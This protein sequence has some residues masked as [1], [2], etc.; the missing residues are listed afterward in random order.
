[1]IWLGVALAAPIDS[2]S[3]EQDDG[4]LTPQAG[5]LQWEWGAP[6]VGPMSGATGTQAWGTRLDGPYLNDATGRLQ[7]PQR[8][9]SGIVEP[10]LVFAHWSDISEGDAAWIE[11]FVDGSWVVLDPPYGYPSSDGFSGSTL[12]WET[13]FF[14]LGDVDDLS[15]VRLVFEA[16]A[17]VQGAGWFIDDL[18]LWDGDVVPPRIAIVAVPVDTEDL[19]G[20]YEVE[21][22]VDD[23]H[24]VVEANIV[25]L[26]DADGGSEPL[27]DGGAS[28]TGGI[29]GLPADTEV[30]WWIEASD[31]LNTAATDAATFRV[32]LPAP[33]DLSGPAGRVVDV[34]ADL[35]WSAPESSHAV[36]AYVIER[37]GVQV[38]EVTDTH[39]TV[40]VL[41]DGADVFAVRARFDVGVGDASDAV[42][43]DVLAP[44]IEGLEPDAGYQGDALTVRVTGDYLLL[45]QDDV[46][47]GLGEGVEVLDVQ[48][49]DVDRA[50]LSVLVADD[51]EQ[52][53][54]DLL[55]RSGDL[56]LSLQDAFEVLDG[57]GRPALTAI[58]PDALRQGDVETVVIEATELAS[59]DVLVDLG[60]GVLIEE[61]R[62]DGATL[63]IDVVV[64][65]NAPIGTHL[66]TVDD[67]LRVLEGVDLRVRDA[68]PP[69]E[70]CSTVGGVPVVGGLVLV[71]F[72]LVRRRR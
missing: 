49:V 65:P 15:E 16:D 63:E 62:V 71:L 3:L 54:R 47:A 5:D 68:L 67:G 2:W 6:T 1:M 37:D 66:V 55:L 48:V 45:A 72:G 8:S 69:P 38:D 40:D 61:V 11:V 35:E 17:S 51:A 28:W 22:V 25:W 42:E 13:A 24:Q 52:G 18:E 59:D 44:S 30:T 23:D 19:D 36:E 33:T 32:R 29:P 4:G 50:E 9:L 12:G 7:L 21:A 41:G 46:D 64:D 14:D 43:L 58:E 10:M 53:P 56:V 27:V 31:G 34:A 39:A 26:T 60:D 70:T 20:P 57:A